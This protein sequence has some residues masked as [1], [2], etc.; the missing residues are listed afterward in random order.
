MQQTTETETAAKTALQRA[1]NVG[2]AFKGEAFQFFSFT[3]R[4]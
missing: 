2:G 4:A 3:Q 1:K